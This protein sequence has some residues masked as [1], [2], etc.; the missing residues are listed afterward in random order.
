MRKVIYIG[1]PFIVSEEEFSKIKV[2]IHADDIPEYYAY[3]SVPASY[4]QYLTYEVSDFALVCLLLYCMEHD[5]DMFF[6]GALSEELYVSITEYLIPAI[7]Q[8]IK[9]YHSIKIECEKLVTIKFNGTHVGTGL[10]CGVDSFYTVI[11]N[12]NH[13]DNSN[14]NL[15]TLTF[16]NAGASGMYGGDE[17]RRIYLERANHFKDIAKKFNCDFLTVDTNF[18]EFLHQ[19]HEAT[20]IFRTLSI[21][22]ALQKYFSRYYFSSSFPF[23]MFRFSAF[24][25]GYY[26]L[27]I[28]ICLSTKNLKFTEVGAETTRLGKIRLIADNNIVQESLN[29]C[30]SETNNCNNCIKCKRTMLNLYIEGKLDLFYKVFDVNYFYKN[31]KKFI[32]WA[33]K[34]KNGADMNEIYTALCNKGEISIFKRFYGLIY[35]T[36]YPFAKKVK[37]FFKH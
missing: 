23:N 1:K 27:L 18:N 9:K 17:A 11:K 4:E 33:I 6:D 21:V 25:P 32:M 12:L 7:C 35:R 30:I 2:S 36:A 10:S 34:N 8:N 16:F 29:V 26:S 28:M 31:K 13:S 22:F 5:Y 24:D 15:T 14:L 19:D 20:H 37:H 3:Y